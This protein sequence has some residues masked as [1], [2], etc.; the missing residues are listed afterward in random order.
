MSWIMTPLRI[1]VYWSSS[2]KPRLHGNP[3]WLPE[4]SYSR[5]GDFRGVPTCLSTPLGCLVSAVHSVS[6]GWL[7]WLLGAPELHPSTGTL[8]GEVVSC[9]FNRNYSLCWCASRRKGAGFTLGMAGSL[10]FSA[11]LFCLCPV[12]NSLQAITSLRVPRVDC[13]GGQKKAPSLLAHLSQGRPPRM[14]TSWQ[15]LGKGNLSLKSARRKRV[16]VF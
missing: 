3:G 15:F 9:Y 14:K 12:P 11:V 5:E 10:L 2:Q 8:Q 7:Y 1:Q 16:V 13:E 6:G 4:A